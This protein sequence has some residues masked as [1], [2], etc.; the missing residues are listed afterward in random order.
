MSRDAP[1]APRFS[2]LF[3][4]DAQNIR[5]LAVA[6]IW[7]L[8]PMA[9]NREHFQRLADECIALSAKSD[10]AHSASEL[11]R[12]SYR[13]L[14]LADPTLPEWEEEDAP[15]QIFGTA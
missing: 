3:C 1:P 9:A 6:F 13:F 4:T 12:I 15:Y 8:A 10:T 5:C 2:G 11:R 7:E 14:Q